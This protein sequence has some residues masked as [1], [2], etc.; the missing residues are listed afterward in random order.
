[1]QHAPGAQFQR[2]AL[3]VVHHLPGDGG[4]VPQLRFPLGAVVVEVVRAVDVGLPVGGGVFARDVGVSLDPLPRLGGVVVGHQKRFGHRLGVRL[5]GKNRLNTRF[6]PRRFAVRHVEFG[7]IH[8]VVDVVGKN[9]HIAV[10]A[11]LE[12]AVDALLLHQHA[13]V[14]PVGYLVLKAES[15]LRIL[16]AQL[17]L[18]LV[19]LE[20]VPAQDSVD[21]LRGALVLVNAAGAR[22]PQAGDVRL[23][24]DAVAAEIRRGLELGKPR[25]A[26]AERAWFSAIRGINGECGIA[27]EVV[28]TQQVIGVGELDADAV[29]LAHALHRLERDDG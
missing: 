13:D 28:V 17:E 7:L 26:A 16:T 27:P 12:V 15:V 8:V 22:E 11:G 4:F 14:R 21:D 19:P 3:S 10:L 2:V 23:D 24:D 18:E 6:Q 25:D 1:M 9:E 29:G 20:A 5:Q